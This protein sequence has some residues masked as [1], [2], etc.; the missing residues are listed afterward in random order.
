MRL[1]NP[2]SKEERLQIPRLL[3]HDATEW[4]CD[5]YNGN[6]LRDIMPGK[7]TQEF[8]KARMQHLINTERTVCYLAHEDAI[9]VSFNDLDYRFDKNRLRIF[10]KS[11]EGLFSPD[12]TTDARDF[13]I[14]ISPHEVLHSALFNIIKNGRRFNEWAKSDKPVNLTV[15]FQNHFPE[16]CYVP[17]GAQQYQNFIAF[18]I[19]DNGRGFPNT[20]KRLFIEKPAPEKGEGGFGLYFL[21]LAA[22]FLRAPVDIQSVP[23]DTNVIFYQ[24]VY[25]TK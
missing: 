9:G 14:F 18:R 6:K 10:L 21:G 8:M 13:P 2:L 20:P 4:W 3:A 7:Y 15:E 17:E 23:G 19:H 1:N 5:L 25:E 22:R 12:L 11:L 24:P 16:A